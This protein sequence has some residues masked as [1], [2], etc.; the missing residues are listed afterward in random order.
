MAANLVVPQ[1]DTPE[2][3]D[4]PLNP[5]TDGI[6]VAGVYFQTGLPYNQANGIEFDGSG[7]LIIK[8][9]VS[10]TKTFAQVLANATG[11]SQAAHETI[12][13][14]VH[15]VA[16]TAYAETTRDTDGRV[17]AYTIWTSAAKT[18]KIRDVVFTRDS[19]RRVSSF[20]VKHYDGAGAVVAS[21][22]LTKTITRDNAGRFQSA[23]WVES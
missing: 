20:V 12:D 4:Q 1:V 22:T 23:A 18:T 6:A 10:G 11:V 14:L 9:A 8:D 2:G 13:S 16:E 15:N 21:Q 17:S 3:F 5:A 7:N 19:M